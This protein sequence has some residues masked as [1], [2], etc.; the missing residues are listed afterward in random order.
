MAQQSLREE[1]RAVR[2][3]SKRIRRAKDPRLVRALRHARKEEREHAASFRR[4]VPQLGME[5]SSSPRW[6]RGVGGAFL[7]GA[8]GAVLGVLV[9][10][11][12]GVRKLSDGSSEVAPIK[13][14]ITTA[15]AV[16]VVGTIAGTVAS[17]IPP[18]C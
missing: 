15:L 14:S 4:L 17:V 6:T 7:G 2:A 5:C 18:E 12:V 1:R 3:Y 13:S 9:G 11:V 10:A 8:A 16:A